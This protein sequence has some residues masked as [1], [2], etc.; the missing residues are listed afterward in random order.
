MRWEELEGREVLWGTEF[1]G[2]QQSSWQVGLLPASLLVRT[3]PEELN[4]TRVGGRAQHWY[5][6]LDRREGPREMGGQIQ[7][8]CPGA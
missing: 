8:V 1:R 3:E 7:G 6:C 2:W 4:S 5:W